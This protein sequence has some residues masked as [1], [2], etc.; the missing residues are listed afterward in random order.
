M[1]DEIDYYSYTPLIVPERP[2][3]VVGSR[4]ARVDRVARLM[5]I[6]TGLPLFLLDRAV[7]HRMGKD[8]RRVVHED[9]LPVLHSVE[10]ELLARPLAQRTPPILALGERTLLDPSL[11][12]Q[13]RGR[14]QIVYVR[15]P[16]T[17]PDLHRVLASVAEV[18]VP[19]AGRHEQ[20]VAQDLLERLGLD[21]ELPDHR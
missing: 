14:A 7:E 17:D 6:L 13:L 11:R 21:V 10:A 15:A 9:G 18:S 4:S 5:S 2:V 12:R 1:A 8:H 16:G 20:R 19:Q 3:A